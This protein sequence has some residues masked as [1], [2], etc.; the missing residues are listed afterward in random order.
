VTNILAKHQ[1]GWKY[2]TEP[3]VTVSDYSAPGYDDSAWATGQAPFYKGG[4][5]HPWGVLNTW[6]YTGGTIVA[7]NTNVWMRRTL[8][9]PGNAFL[10]FQVPADDQ[11]FV[12]ID[13]V[14]IPLTN[15]AQGL[16]EATSYVAATSASLVVKVHDSAATGGANYIFIDIEISDVPGT[17]FHSSTFEVEGLFDAEIV[18]HFTNFITDSF[19]AEIAATGAPALHPPFIC[20]PPFPTTWSRND[21]P[22]AAW[23]CSVTSSS[24]W[25]SSDEVVDLGVDFLAYVNGDVLVDVNGER[26]KFIG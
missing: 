25:V 12:W 22:P 23:A 5:P 1:V 24:S 20:Q 14:E 2:L 18:D 17:T 8:A 9:L 16:Y 21:S 4:P 6:G 3:D 15:V 19:R 11:P 7:D 26:L 13:G 10:V